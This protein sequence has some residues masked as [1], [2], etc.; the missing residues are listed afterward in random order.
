[1]K[2]VKRIENFYRWYKSQKKNLRTKTDFKA[3]QYYYSS[4]E[5]LTQSTQT[6]FSNHKYATENVRVKKLVAEMCVSSAN[7]MLTPRLHRY[8]HFE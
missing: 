8:G 7:F 2:A 4:N 1:M 6:S 5:K 3:E